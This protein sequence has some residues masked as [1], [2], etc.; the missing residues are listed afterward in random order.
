[1][2]DEHRKLIEENYNIFYEFFH[3]RNIY[4]ED[5]Q[6][7]CVERVCENIDRFD[8]TRGKISTFMFSVCD[9]AVAHHIRF[10]NRHK[11]NTFENPTFSLYLTLYGDEESSNFTYEDM[12]ASEED[13]INNFINTDHYLKFIEHLKKVLSKKEFDTLDEYIKGKTFEEISNKFGVTKQCVNFNLQ[14]ARR[15]ARNSYN[16]FMGEKIFNV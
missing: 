7:E 14:K 2:T 13:S 12:I 15:K 11:R 6:Q 16:I 8:E 4:D 9:S 3:K 1:M 10:N 5:I